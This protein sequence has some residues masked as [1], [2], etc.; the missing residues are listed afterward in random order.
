[1]TWHQYGLAS[2][3]DAT[4]RFGDGRLV[5]GPGAG[6]GAFTVH[7]PMVPVFTAGGGYTDGAGGVGR[8]DQR[9]VQ[10]RAD[11]LCFTSAPLQEPVELF[12]SATF[13][14][15]VRSNAP[16]DDVC[17]TLSEVASDGRVENLAFGAVRGKGRFEVTLSPVHAALAAGAR[18][19]VAIA[20]SAYPEIDVNVSAGAATQVTRELHPGSSRLRVPFVAPR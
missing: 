2:M 11:V 1:M 5:D 4:T 10:D 18:L 6:V 19:R 16:S 14:T 15:E 20:P 12:G 13:A 9:A 3:S 7:Q 8:A 17:V